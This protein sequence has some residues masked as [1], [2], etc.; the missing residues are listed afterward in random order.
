MH[1]DPGPKLQARPILVLILAGAA[2]TG[3]GGDGDGGNNP[4]PPNTINVQNNSFNPS[5]LTITQGT[6]ITFSWVG[7]GHNVAP[8]STNPLAEPAS[9]GL[10]GTHNAPFSFA[11]T[12]GTQGVFRFYCTVHGA[13]PTPGTVTGMAGTITVQP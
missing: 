12:F 9:A 13:E 6:Q 2:M 11:V 1:G 10:P 7:S 8:A 4:P 3:C 5:S